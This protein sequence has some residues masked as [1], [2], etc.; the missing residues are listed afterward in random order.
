MSSFAFALSEVLDAPDGSAIPEPRFVQR[1][2]ERLY[3]T[4]L[5][6]AGARAKSKP[7]PRDLVETLQESRSSL[8]RSRSPHR[9]A[10]G[11]RSPICRRKVFRVSEAYDTSLPQWALPSDCVSTHSVDDRPL[12]AWALPPQDAS[13]VRPDSSSTCVVTHTNSQSVLAPGPSEVSSSGASTAVLGGSRQ[14]ASTM[15]PAPVLD[16]MTDVSLRR[17]PRVLVPSASSTITAVSVQHMAGGADTVQLQSWNETLRYPQV[18]EEAVR[19]NMQQ[20][21]FLC[22]D[23]GVPVLPDFELRYFAS[24]IC[25]TGAT[26]LEVFQ[27]VGI[28]ESALTVHWVFHLRQLWTRMDPRVS[29]A[30]KILIQFGHGTD[31]GGLDGILRLKYLAPAVY[32]DGDDAVGHYSQ[33]SLWSD[34]HSLTEMY[35]RVVSSGKWA[36][37]VIVGGEVV[38]SD[39][40]HTMKS[41]SGAEAQR[42]CVISGAVHMKKDKKW[43]LH[44]NLTRIT[45]FTVSV[46]K[47][48]QT[49]R[50]AGGLPM[51]TLPPSR[52][53]RL[54][55]SMR[56]GAI[57]LPRMA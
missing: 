40:H 43:V 26:A 53:E 17:E 41:G 32:A 8:E 16:G 30:Q 52:F 50:D 18:P 27:R 12:P 56:S 6:Q 38:C 13:D 42:A 28:L 48:F 3:R 22:Q 20:L 29:D 4:R 14:F 11:V 19:L 21:T 57:P 44:S 25:R 33:A 1:A 49:R 36:Q 51:F 5:E 35:D 37:P 7:G 34:V 23:S 31:T 54:S 9:E 45:N 24:M 10:R 39:I 55:T 46:R 2:R 15:L 47:S